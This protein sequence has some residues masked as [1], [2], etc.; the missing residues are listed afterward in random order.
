MD[1]LFSSLFVIMVLVKVADQIVNNRDFS[2]VQC[3]YV[4]GVMGW[5]I[6]Q[7]VGGNLE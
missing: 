2:F 6:Q 4:N 5:Q 7:I 1:C 3:G